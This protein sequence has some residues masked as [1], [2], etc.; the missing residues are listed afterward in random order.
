[1]ASSPGPRPSSERESAQER[2]TYLEGVVSGQSA[3]KRFVTA[4][5]VLAE[6]PGVIAD[7]AVAL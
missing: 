1:M 6:V 5:K 2:L 4:G 3:D 7:A